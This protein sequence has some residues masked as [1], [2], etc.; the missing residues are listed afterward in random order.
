[1][2]ASVSRLKKSAPPHEKSALSLA[3][4]PRS[5]AGPV[6][7]SWS[8]AKHPLSD[9]AVRRIARAA[10][11]HGERAGLPIAVVFVTDKALARMHGRWLGDG[12][13]TDVISFD[14]SGE[15][16]GPAGELYIS[17]QRAAAV[18]R[19]RGVR[20]ERELAL[21]L[22]HGC[23]HLCGFDDHGARARAKMRSAERAVLAGLGF[24][25]DPTPFE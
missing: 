17:V 5:A 10:L 11:H 21:Y 7:I 24:E 16:G 1:V 6:E 3:K 22:V 13:P 25:D 12:R 18:A 14:L 8:T 9:R 15:G 4:S 19:R 23:L 2:D 20:V